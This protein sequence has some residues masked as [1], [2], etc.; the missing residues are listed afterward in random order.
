[1]EVKA[2]ATLEIDSARKVFE[3]SFSGQL[4][5]IKLGT[6]GATA[7]KFVLDMSN[8]LSS[9]PQFW[10]V[11]TLETNFKA[12]EQ[13]GVFLFAKGTLQ[14]NLTEFQKTETLTLTG[15]GPNGTDLTRTFVLPK[16]SFS[17]ELVGQV[18]IRPPGAQTDLV[19]MQGGFFLS[20]NPERFELFATAELSFGVGDAQITF[21]AAT[22][23]IVIVTGQTPGQN[24]GVAGFLKVSSSAALGIPGV[25]DLFKISGSVT[26]MFNTTRQEQHFQIPQAF[27][28]LLH[29]GE[30]TVIAIFASAP[31]LDGTRNPNAP[32]GGE[33]YVQ[34]TIQAELTIGGVISLTGFIQL[35]V[36]VSSAGARLKL[37][38]AVSTQV[39]LLGSL[40]GTLNLNIFIGSETG[41]VGRVFLAL[42]GNGIPGIAFSGAFLLEINTFTNPAAPQRT[43]E[44]FKLR[45]RTINGRTAFDGFERDSAGNLV[46]VSEE[47]G[48]VGGFRFVFAGQLMIANT[49]RVDA[50][51]KFRIELAGSN[52]GIELVMNG[53]MSLNPIGQVALIDSGF[54]INPEGIVARFNLQL[55]VNFGRDVGLK[56]NV[57]ALFTLNTTGRV[58]SLGSS[59]VDPGFRLRLE[60]SVAAALR[61]LV[62]PR[63]PGLRG[64]GRR[65]YRHR[66]RCR[67]RAQP[68]SP[69]RRRRLGLL[70]RGLRP[71]GGE[72]DERRPTGR[73]GPL[74][75]A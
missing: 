7:G 8:T 3:L 35:E 11:A 36:A 34:A 22:G 53:T 47:I 74:V 32:P 73:G 57:S 70:H 5:I 10:G 15:L 75:H 33:V 46:V 24:A 1:M 16:L 50:E 52:P 44:T 38:G 21:G 49:V 25:G 13:Y 17:L 43:I 64:Q 48:V 51:V 39:P 26:V 18:R 69:G 42:A 67:L 31:S 65:R 60:G 40:T 14:I 41:V 28:P 45:T 12:L 63:R 59:S 58:Q 9:A 66:R 62:Q 2:Q 20:I 4:K 68:P 29:P 30:P 56:F 54:R 23:L 19:R 55:D 61:R 37:T 27:L 72:H 6:V 71:P